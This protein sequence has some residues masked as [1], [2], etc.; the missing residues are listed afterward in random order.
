MA[1]FQ[2]PVESPRPDGR[3]P[4]PASLNWKDGPTSA[5]QLDLVLR[6]D[7]PRTACRE[8]SPQPHE[9]LPRLVAPERE[10][11][12]GATGF[13]PRT[14]VWGDISGTPFSSNAT[15]AFRKDTHCVT[16]VQLPAKGR[17][18]GVPAEADSSR[19]I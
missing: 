10:R 19:K 3:G 12:S 9:P 6:K 8:P 1:P 2:A 14:P 5:G 7:Q 15:T 4:G 11:Y 13:V 18:R 17:A 16:R